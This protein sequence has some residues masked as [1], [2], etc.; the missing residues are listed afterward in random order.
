MMYLFVLLGSGSFFSL[1]FALLFRFDPFHEAAKE[2]VE[3]ERDE[4]RLENWAMVSACVLMF[5]I[6]G[7]FLYYGLVGDLKTHKRF[8]DTY[9]TS[10]KTVR[11]ERNW[12]V[13]IPD[14]GSSCPIR[15]VNLTITMLK[16]GQYQFGLYEDTIIHD[17]KFTYNG[18]LNGAPLKT[19]SEN[20]AK[21]PSQMV[22]EK[23]NTKTVAINVVFP[24][25]QSEIV[26]FRPYFDIVYMNRTHRL[27]KY[28]NVRKVEE[29]TDR[30]KD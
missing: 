7:A 4:N 5:T 6:V 16:S 14:S 28:P 21:T 27:D 17:G 15:E 3:R 19:W 25:G 10:D 30:A 12:V 1:G 24:S 23:V 8:I 20:I 29:W 2:A 26:E 22:Y 9:E 18:P 13:E 11:V